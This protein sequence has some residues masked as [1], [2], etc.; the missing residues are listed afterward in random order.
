MVNITIDGRAVSVAEGTS[1][2]DAAR[3]IGVDL[4][5]LCYLKGYNDIGACRVCLV[6]VKG[7][8]RLVASCN[9]AVAEGMDILTNSPR[10]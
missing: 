3:S 9:T 6:E 2:L 8:E 4:P 1:I 10:V 5:T 7:I